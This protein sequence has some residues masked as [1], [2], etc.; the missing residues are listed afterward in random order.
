MPKRQVWIELIPPEL[1]PAAEELCR[2]VLAE[3]P[4]AFVSVACPHFDSDD[5]V[6]RFRMKSEKRDREMETRSLLSRGDVE[7]EIVCPN[8]LNELHREISHL[9]AD[10]P[11][12]EVQNA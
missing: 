7:T 1:V 8:I 11:P 6:F 3:Y 10:G 2:L 4:S 12:K 5:L 9:E